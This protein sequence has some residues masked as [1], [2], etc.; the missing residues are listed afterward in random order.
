MK[1]Y[2]VFLVNENFNECVN[3]YLHEKDA[4]NACK[5]IQGKLSGASQVRVWYLTRDLI[6]EEK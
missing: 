3:V 2:V 6:E 4:E 5:S 1:C